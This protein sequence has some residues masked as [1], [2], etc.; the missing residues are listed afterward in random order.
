M[1]NQLNTTYLEQGILFANRF[2]IEQL[3]GT[4]GMG[5]V[6]LAKDTAYTDL[7]VALKVLHRDFTKD[8]LQ[9]QRFL[10]EIDILHQVEHPNIIRIL[11]SGKD[12]ETDLHYFAMD[13]L[14]NGNLEDRFSSGS[15]NAEEL[16]NTL[17]AC[18]NAL[19][20]LHAL[21]I[22]HRDLKPDNILF[23][24]NGEIK[25]TDFG[26]SRTSNSK[27]TQM[28]QKLGSIYYI[29]PEIWAGK[30]PTPSADYYS[31]G[32]ILY[33]GLTG[34]LPF[35]GRKI[36][37]LMHQ[38][39]TSPPIEPYKQKVG[40]P[41]WLSDLTMKLL[42]KNPETRLANPEE[43]LQTIEKNPLPPNKVDL[44][45]KINLKRFNAPK[46]KTV[47]FS[48]KATRNRDD[49]KPHRGKTIVFNISEKSAFVFEVELPSRDFIYFGCFLASL[50][51][52]D[53]YL[54][55]LGTKRFGISAEGNPLLRNMM[56]NIHPD[57][58][59]LSAKLL[60]ISIVIILTLIAKKSRWVKDLIGTLSCIYLFAAIIP[61]CYLL[62]FKTH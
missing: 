18:C 32:M 12:Q 34:S 4:G 56:E 43:I 62:Y 52:A 35:K 29:A 24:K 30:E 58:A 6:Y 28:N 14:N 36:Q 5:M 3:L 8:E 53:G 10:Q 42:D 47:V 50:Q 2:L 1:F 20:T 17:I 27:L 61:W 46:K 33:E 11:S 59:L 49:S 41:G 54:T 38:H 51:V 44:N 45:S 7:N 16:K 9:R 23:S 48:L 31:L 13:Y 26:V 37:E 57:Q 15:I 60:A 39:L 40:I 55:S 19:K 21:N 22:V 25:I